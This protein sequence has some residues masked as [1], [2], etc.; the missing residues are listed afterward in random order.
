[1]PSLTTAT[2]F[3][4][5][6][7]FQAFGG[8]GR[9]RRRDPGDARRVGHREVVARLQRRLQRDLDLAAE[10]HEERAVGDVDDLDARHA[11]DGLGDRLHVLRVPGEHGDVADLGAALDPDEVDRTERPPASPIASARRANVPGRSSRR[12]RIVALNEA[13]GCFV[14]TGRRLS[15]SLA[16]RYRAAGAAGDARRLGRPR[17][18]AS[19]TAGAT[20]RLKT[21][22]IT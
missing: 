20:S 15:P 10:V 1:M 17:A 11:L 7:R 2:V 12:T 6:V 22:G 19:A 14:V 4:L 9:D 3:C 13:D 18:T 16:H 8:V 21:L 5:I